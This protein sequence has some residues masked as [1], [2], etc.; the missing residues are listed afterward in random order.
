[1]EVDTENERVKRVA[2]QALRKFPGAKKHEHDHHHNE[3]TCPQLN[4][5][6]LREKAEETVV[7]HDEE[8]LPQIPARYTQCSPPD[9]FRVYKSQGIVELIEAVN[10]KEH[11]AGR[12]AEKDEYTRAKVFQKTDDAFPGKD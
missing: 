5:S 7:V 4:Q 8:S 11:K 6:A 2:P 3:H 9:G 12:K 10:G 1:M